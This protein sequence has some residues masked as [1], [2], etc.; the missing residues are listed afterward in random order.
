M[1]FWRSLWGGRGISSPVETSFGKS[2]ASVSCL[3]QILRHKQNEETVRRCRLF[4]NPRYIPQN[5]AQALKVAWKS[6]VKV[7]TWDNLSVHCVVPENIHT[8]P[9]E[10]FLVW[11]PHPSGNSILVSY[12]RSK[13]WAFGT[14]LPLGISFNLPCCGHGYFLRLHTSQRLSMVQNNFSV[15]FAISKWIHETS[16][17]W[18]VEERLQNTSRN[19]RIYVR[20]LGSYENEA[21]KKFQA[22][23]GF[24]HM[25]SAIPVQCFRNLGPGHSHNTPVDYKIKS[26]F[27]FEIN[28]TC[29]CFANSHK[30]THFHLPFSEEK[31]VFIQWSVLQKNNL[32]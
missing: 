11:N 8:P 32:Q 28:L 20:K 17:P 12:F 30:Y 22:W 23:T 2:T 27:F 1:R 25:T 14:P 3:R 7:S 24:E 5:R 4:Y 31:V 19:R 13:N 6:R 16:F 26:E 15:H 10:G 29:G 21:R 9:T 18:I